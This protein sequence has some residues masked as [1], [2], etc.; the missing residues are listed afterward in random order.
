MSVLTDI[1]APRRGTK[2]RLLVIDGEPLCETS[3]DVVAHLAL[4]AGST[5]AVDDLLA[6]IATAAPVCARDRAVRLLTYRDRSESALVARLRDDG[7]PEQ[8]ALAVTADL[9]RLGFLD[10]ER[11]AKQLARTLVH[12]KGLGRAR[13]TR[14]LSAKGVDAQLADRVLDELIDPGSEEQAARRL[15]S[16]EARRAGASVDRVIR[17]LLRRGY[18]LTI[19]LRAAKAAFEASAD[20][21]DLLGCDVDDPDRFPGPDPFD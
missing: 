9:T 3:A 8:V 17:R 19:A 21:A 5:V 13:A 1:R 11:Y 10:D 12:A 4:R 6:R 7:Y 20:D 18:P 16:V 2:E 15:A 14:E